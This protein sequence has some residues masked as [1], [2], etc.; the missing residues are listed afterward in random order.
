MDKVKLTGQNLDWVSN[1]RYKN[2]SLWL[3]DEASANI[4]E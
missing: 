1:S 4:I 3:T 2:K